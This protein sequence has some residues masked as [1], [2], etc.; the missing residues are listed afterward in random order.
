M[1]PR[2]PRQSHSEALP[3]LESAREDT[4]QMSLLALKP[5][6]PSGPD[7]DAAKAFFARAK[8]SKAAGKP[9]EK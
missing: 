1:T 4:R 5:F 7:F 3:E 2:F 9:E 6:I 8:K